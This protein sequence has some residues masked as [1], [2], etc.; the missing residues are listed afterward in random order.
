MAVSYDRVRTAAWLPSSPDASIVARYHALPFPE[1]W[2]DA[3]LDLCNTGR[4]ED[5]EPYRTVPTHRM[6]QVLQAVAPDH[7]AL[8]RPAT[9]QDEPAYWLYVP[10]DAPL[11]PDPAFRALRN[12]WLADLRPEP[13]HRA[14]LNRTRAMLDESPPL[15]RSVEVELLRCPATGGGTA[16]PRPYQYALTTDWL[17]RRLLALDPYDFGGGRLRFRALPR[18]PRD[19]GAELVSQPLPFEVKGRTW[20][21]SIVLNITLHTV[22]FD[23]LPRLHLHSGIRRWAT[24]VSGT[25]QR[26]HLPYRSRTTVLL[27][28]RVPWLPGAPASGR[29]AVARLERRWDKE[30]EAW[31]TDWV[32][33]G[34]ARM[35]RGISLTEP[36]PE[37]GEILA[38]PERWL[39]DDMRAA[40]VYSTAMGAHGVAAGLMSDQRS[41][42]VEWAEQAIPAE[43]RPVPTRPHTRRGSTTPANVAPKPRPADKATEEIRRAAN[44][45]EA[46]AFAVACL[47]PSDPSSAVPVLGARL[48]WQTPDMR[49]AAIAALVAHLG[50]KNDGDAPTSAAFAAAAPENPVMLEWQSPELTVRLRCLKLPGRLAGDLPIPDDARR[51]RATVTAA[52]AD[53]RAAAAAF[54]AA[55]GPGDIPSLALVELDRPGEFTSTNHNPKFALWLGFADAGALTQFVTVPKKVKGYDSAGNA[56][57]RAREAWDDGLRQ[58]GARV[59]PEPAVAG[60]L[61]DGLRYAAIWLVRKNRRSRT[62]WE[63][64]VPVAVLVTPERPG[65]GIARIQGWDPEA[66]DGAG[67]WVPYPVM[68]LR[69]TRLAEISAGEPIPTGA[70]PD[71]AGSAASPDPAA[72]GG[73]GTPG[74]RPSWRKNMDG[75]RRATEQWLQK[76]LASLRGTPTL[77]LAH[78]QNARSHWTWLQDG[79]VEPDRLRTGLAP[80]RRLDPDLRLVR[81]RT[82][83]GRETAQWWGVHP[84]GGP[85]GLPSHL[86]VAAGDDGMGGR[87]FWSTTPKAHQFRTSAVEADKLAPRP[88]R[89]GPRKGEPTVDTHIPAWNPDLVELA[90]LGCH[91]ADGDDPEALAL[92]VHQMRRP[93]D[94]P[95]ALSLP[96]PLHLAGLAQEYVLPIPVQD[97]EQA[98]PSMEMVA[99]EDP[100]AVEISETE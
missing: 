25:T 77:L 22:P 74:H 83:I 55:D 62:R 82:R 90:V 88:L 46:V 72:S 71:P 81:V 91:P 8:P 59:H 61:P 7:L 23:P 45:R 37:A 87:V 89:A 16:A 58:L 68:L 41:R 64:Y 10:D 3:L 57:H 44:L 4:S 65:R 9:S 14:V 85:N 30:N 11:L 50:L 100:A 18:S 94:Y 53:R 19:Q 56:D 47:R 28:P 79:Q 1:Q 84:R 93:P 38:E 54:L 26:L 21:Y 12:A 35:M 31:T 97:G 32:N 36:F 5:A 17:A 2:R 20:W 78:A 40:V 51:T 34:P 27:R 73:D 66:D 43:L 86:W 76:V 63:G 52:L 29:F 60:G 75:Q 33:G 42:I 96:L 39:T 49:D 67:A 95:E 6:E 48:L 69:L 24:L 80:A 99:D 13:E 15:W 92:A 98:V 70:S